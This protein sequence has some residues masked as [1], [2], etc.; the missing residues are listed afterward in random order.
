MRRWWTLAAA[1][2]LTAALAQAG[3]GGKT[4][5]GTGANCDASGVE[6]L[7]FASD[8]AVAGQYD[9]YLY[10]LQAGGYHLLSGVNSPAAADSNPTVSGDARLVAYTTRHLGS[11]DLVIDDRATCTFVDMTSI[12]TTA[13]EVQPAFSYDGNRLAFARDTLGHRQVRMLNGAMP[14][15]Y[16]PVPGLDD[17]SHNDASPVLDLHGARLAFTSDRSGRPEVYVYDTATHA[18]LATP[19]INPGGAT[20]VDPAL[21]ANGR[22]L[23]FASDRD[24]TGGTPSF[25]IYV[26]DLTGDSLVALPGINSS[27]DERHPSMSRSNASN[28]NAPPSLIA[29]QS[30]R[31]AA[32]GF[33]LYVY[34]LVGHTVTAIQAKAGDDVQ[35]WLVWP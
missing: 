8:R 26:Y 31:V 27:A 23:A 18:L 29:F 33:D 35:P 4:T 14:P 24:T 9:I 10:D 15:Q 11:G 25:G 2:A 16:V 3:C 17:P 1:A 7:A 28:A 6:L 34:T 32:D 22:W 12:N 5:V 30:N 20:D 21:S 13:E 19:G